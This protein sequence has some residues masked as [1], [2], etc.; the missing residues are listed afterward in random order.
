MFIGSGKRGYAAEWVRHWMCSRNT[1]GGCSALCVFCCQIHCL[2]TPAC[3]GGP[4]GTYP[5]V[6]WASLACPHGRTWQGRRLPTRS[7]ALYLW[8]LC[9]VVKSDGG[10]HNENPSIETTCLLSSSI[11]V[12][13]AVFCLLWPCVVCLVSCFSS[14][15]WSLSFSNFLVPGKYLETSCVWNV[16]V[17]SSKLIN[18]VVGI[19]IS[20]LLLHK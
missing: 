18:N 5:W 7:L 16:F 8:V 4:C 9:S 3:R 14:F 2:H 12:I 19:L 15:K 1:L 13:L 6:R 10:L 20:Y 11:A 17:L